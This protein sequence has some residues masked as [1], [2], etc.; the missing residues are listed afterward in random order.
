M[1][2]KFVY[3]KNKNHDVKYATVQHCVKVHGAKHMEIGNTKDIVL[4]VL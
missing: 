3:T 1:E 2:V 4:R